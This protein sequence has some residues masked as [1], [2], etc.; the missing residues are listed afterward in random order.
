MKINE[1]E[2]HAQ[3][4]EGAGYMQEDIIKT[5]KLTRTNEANKHIY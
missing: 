2:M 5:V 3:C 4:M 1:E